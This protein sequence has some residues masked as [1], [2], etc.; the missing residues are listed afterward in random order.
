MVEETVENACDVH[1]RIFF[2]VLRYVY[3][4]VLMM[5]TILFII[6]FL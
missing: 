4:N 1:I 6:M 5:S 3:Y 2:N